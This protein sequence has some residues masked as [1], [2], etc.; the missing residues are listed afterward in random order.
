VEESCAYLHF[1]EIIIQQNYKNYHLKV[2]LILSDQRKEQYKVY[3]P[4]D[5][6]KYFIIEN[7]KPLIRGLYRLKKAKD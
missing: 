2:D 7:N 3:P 4:K 1:M 5:P 6:D